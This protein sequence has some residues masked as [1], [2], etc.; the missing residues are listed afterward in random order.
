MLDWLTIYTKLDDYYMYTCMWNMW[1]DKDD[2]K[3]S[4]NSS[5][6]HVLL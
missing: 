6:V 3:N 2:K 5:K 1:Q 4:A